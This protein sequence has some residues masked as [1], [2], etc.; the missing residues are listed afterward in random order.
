M[1]NE[2]NP[3][4]TVI[5][6]IDLKFYRAQHMSNRCL[7]NAQTRQQIKVIANTAQRDNNLYLPL[8]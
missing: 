2:P 1:E 8:Y 7:T 6:Y 5:S 4:V 3:E